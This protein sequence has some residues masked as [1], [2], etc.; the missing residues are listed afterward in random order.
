MTKYTFRSIASGDGC[1]E[2]ATEGIGAADAS[3][4][5]D[6]GA[7]RVGLAA[8][9]ASGSVLAPTLQPAVDAMRPSIVARMSQ[10]LGIERFILDTHLL[11][12]GLS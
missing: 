3:G 2:G 1:A 7:A 11:R 5:A 6:G 4:V 8:G 10:D 9:I 12:F